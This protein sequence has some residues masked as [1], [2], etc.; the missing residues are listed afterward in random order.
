MN[1]GRRN[2]QA[3]PGSTTPCI[4]RRYSAAGLALLGLFQ[5][6]PTFADEPQLTRL[7]VES[8]KSSTPVRRDA[9]EGWDRVSLEAEVSRPA[10]FPD[11]A[12]PELR[13]LETIPSTG[14]EPRQSLES[15]LPTQAD[16]QDPSLPEGLEWVGPASH[17]RPT[18]STLAPLFG[19]D[20]QGAQP[21]FKV[22]TSSA[23]T[24]TVK[25]PGEPP[26]AEP[27][28]ILFEPGDRDVAA[29]PLAPPSEAALDEP[30]LDLTLPVEEQP[31][32]EG[33]SAPEPDPE[34]RRRTA[35]GLRTSSSEI[36][37]I[38]SIQPYYDYDPDGRDPC[39]LCPQPEGCEPDPRLQ[40]PEPALVPVSGTGERFFP[41]LEYRW[42][43]S[44]LHHNPLYFE[45]PLLERYGHVHYS[46]CVEPAF[47]V[48]RFG[49]Q[50]LSLPY[51]LALDPVCRD[52]YAL[53]WYRPG[54]FTPKLIYQPPLNGI[55]AATAVESYIYLGLFLIP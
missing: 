19:D 14:S 54:D 29:A 20:Q 26:A 25:L 8:E 48:A 47:S 42:A 3:V 4:R 31:I 49:V 32:D 18:S 34:D 52:Q 5:I 36:R 1:F 23:V 7:R 33:S 9:D 43:A 2:T 44:N 37:P 16:P 38:T 27:G 35:S 53:G 50:V 21:A 51:Q 6:A 11:Q 24:T 45:N 17:D 41:H 46:D 55:A 10:P 39:E 28:R 40:C 15:L 30:A 22:I 12:P 13:L